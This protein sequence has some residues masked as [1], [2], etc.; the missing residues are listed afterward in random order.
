MALSQ[1]ATFNEIWSDERIAS[2]LTVTPPEQESADFHLLYHAYKHMRPSDF[3]RFLV[4]FD[5][6]GRDRAA[7]N[8][9][10]QSLAE[11]LQS[12]PNAQDFLRL[13]NRV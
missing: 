13:L 12:H 6:Q 10:G 2:F 3:E 11:I 7:Q 8:R 5:E 9:H 4:L 1:P